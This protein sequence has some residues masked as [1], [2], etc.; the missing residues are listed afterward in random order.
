[1]S[2]PVLLSLFFFL[3]I[4]PPPRSTLFPYTTLFR[5]P[6]GRFD[7]I[8]ADASNPPGT[9]RTTP[10][11]SY[12]GSQMAAACLRPLIA[13][14][15]IVANTAKVNRLTIWPPSSLARP[16]PPGALLEHMVGRLPDP[17]VK[18]VAAGRSTQARC[19]A[20]DGGQVSTTAAETRVSFLLT[21]VFP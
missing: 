12:C 14:S 3:I 21:P 6:N 9:A 15:S 17:A 18:V 1:M 8:R 5:S 13:A 20:R 7:E 16:G 19:Q 2:C 10:P 11:H 4:R